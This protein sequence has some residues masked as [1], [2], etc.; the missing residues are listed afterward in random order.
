MHYKLILQYFI[1]YEKLLSFVYHLSNR[2][3]H[4]IQIHVRRYSDKAISPKLEIKYKLPGILAKS[5]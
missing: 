4:K 5:L 3:F 2:V 1:L